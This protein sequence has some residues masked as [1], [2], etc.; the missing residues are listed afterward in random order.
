MAGTDGELVDLDSGWE[1]LRGAADAD[2]LPAT[3]PGTAA[4]ALRDAGLWSP[5]DKL[6][7]DAEDWWFR[8]RFPRPE[9]AADADEIA[10]ELDGIATV[11]EVLL[12]GESLLES[13][14]MFATHSVDVTAKLAD[15]NELVIHCRALA[16]L[17][18]ERRRPR[19]RWRTRVVGEQNLRFFRTSMLG[20]APGFAPGPA[21]VGPW[22]PVR[23]R[24]RSAI[25]LDSV[26]L[27]PHLEGDLGVVEASVEVRNLDGSRPAAIALELSGPTG[28][29]R[30]ELKLDGARGSG[31][32]DVP[33]A[34]RWWPHTH[35]EPALYEAQLVVDERVT[36]AGRL[37]FRDLAPGPDADHEIDS[38]GLQLHVNGVSVF[39]RGAVWTPVDAI[40]LAPNEADLRAA[41]E[42]VC[43]A[44]MNVVRV[45]G[46]G[47]YESPAFHDLC[48]EL[49][50]LVWQDFMFA[51]FDYPIAD[52]AF[53]ATVEAEAGAVL[54]ALAPHPSLAV[55]CGNSEVEQQAAMMGLGPEASRSELF[56]ELLPAAIAA[57]GAD[58]PYVRSAPTGG[59]FPFRTNAGVANYFGVGGYMRPLT[60][61][62]AAEV[63][64]ASECLAFAN[65]PD[66][67]AVA[68][69][70]G[71]GPVAPGDDP[72]WKAGVARDVG[73][74]WD[75]EDVRDH[76][77]QE[78][79]GVDAAALRAEDPERYLELSR[80]VSGEVMAE[81][82]GEWRRAA[83]PCGGGIVLW[84]RDL[85]AGAGWGLVDELGHP[86]VAY[87]HLRRA[88][89]PV[90]A[91]ATDEGLNGIVAH[92]AND[93]PEALNARLRVAVY[94]GEQQIEEVVEEI[95]LGPHDSLDRD[96]EAMLGRFFDLSWAYRF[97]PP[98]QDLVVVSLDDPDGVSRSQVFRFPAAR[99]IEPQPAAAI[100]LEADL[101]EGEGTP[102]L[103]L[104]SRGFAYGVRVH[105]HGYLPADDAFSI[106]PGGTR[107]VALRAIGPNAPAPEVAVTALNLI[108]RVRA[109]AA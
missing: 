65:V 48:D 1:L 22:R 29:H 47:A 55:L 4:A 10:L 70:F 101:V 34:A 56:D 28:T 20:R 11:A 2:P 50:L 53:R 45:V 36:P 24:L 19:A 15:E 59:S 6:D 41:L 3:V 60:D 77:L 57:A 18:A 103:Q 30:T 89:A 76:Y 108:G 26:R 67:A 13:E 9:G 52:E 93:R 74:E 78:L 23:L 40:G 81:V 107:T 91:W 14:S 96:V 58:A 100:G 106:E 66:E 94:R 75:F 68:R 8:T 71:D 25:A 21:P 85:A 73:A 105:A 33:G 104:R 35:G 32:L 7:F 61:V 86:K 54:D 87:H 31:R 80:A 64:F 62:R 98:A 82:F 90:C 79:F 95:E 27:R 39:A 83:S 51:N 49:G 37:G 69:V 84:M 88:L 46:T 44:G 99:P 63:R 38:D 43:D 17:L 16:P 42:G 92:V 109:G 5:G 72:R 12:N 97:G 102:Q